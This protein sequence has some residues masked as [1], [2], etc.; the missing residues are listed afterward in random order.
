MG[1]G[2]LIS[3]LLTWSL[4][5][6]M[7]VTGAAYASV[8]TELAMAAGTTAILWKSN[9][10]FGLAS[11]VVKMAIPIGLMIF[12]G[13]KLKGVNVGLSAVVASIVYLGS[14]FV[15]RVIDGTDI[16]D[17]KTLIGKRAMAG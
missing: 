10:K 4:V 13:A 8:L 5:R 16:S 2:C 7:G 3:C 14:L 11:L 17:L 9:L 1:I 6:G 12:I 15:V